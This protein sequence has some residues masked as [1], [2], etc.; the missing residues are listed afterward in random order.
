MIGLSHRYDGCHMAEPGLVNAAPTQGW[1][2][3]QDP[4]IPYT[5]GWTLLRRD[6]D[7]DKEEFKRRQ[8]GRCSPRHESRMCSSSRQK[9][10][11]ATFACRAQLLRLLCHIW[12]RQLL[13]G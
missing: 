2:G 10:W 1:R 12:P 11:T 13:E 8:L 5:V 6:T 9:L 4:F 7:A 3:H